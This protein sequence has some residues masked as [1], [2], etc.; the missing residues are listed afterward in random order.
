MLWVTQMPPELAERLL[1][2]RCASLEEALVL[3]LKDL[4]RGARIGIMP[5]ANATIPETS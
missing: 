3:G 4:P 5:W 2:R 1:L